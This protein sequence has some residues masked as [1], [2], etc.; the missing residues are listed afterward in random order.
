MKNSNH[1]WR[2][3][4]NYLKVGIMIWQSEIYLWVDKY[5]GPIIDMFIKSNMITNMQILQL[6][7]YVKSITLKGLSKG[8]NST[9]ERFLNI[10]SQGYEK[11]V[12]INYYH[13][14]RK[15]V[16]KLVLWIILTNHYFLFFILNMTLPKNKLDIFLFLNFEIQI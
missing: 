2:R 13:F 1:K 16:K 9:K 8:K 15:V 14:V 7:F 10:L 12:T 3:K 4:I 6:I 5:K 11:Y